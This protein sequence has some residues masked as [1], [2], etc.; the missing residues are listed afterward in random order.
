MKDVRGLVKQKLHEEL[1][2]KTRS[3]APSGVDSAS[4]VSDRGAVIPLSSDARATSDGDNETTTNGRAAKAAR[5]VMAQLRELAVPEFETTMVAIVTPLMILLRRA[6][7]VHH[8]MLKTLASPAGKAAIVAVS[9][10]DGA[11]DY[12]AEVSSAYSHRCNTRISMPGRDYI[13][14][15]QSALMLRTS[16]SLCCSG[17]GEKRRCTFARLRTRPGAIHATLKQA[18]GGKMS[19]RARAHLGH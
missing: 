4:N 19:L 8:A 2:A 7:I 5:P 14:E 6:H 15:K 13:M 16:V 3:L 12:A 9:D 1:S 10:S 11:T 18:E 17:A